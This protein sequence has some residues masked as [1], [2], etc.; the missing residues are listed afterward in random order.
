VDLLSNQVLE[1]FLSSLMV[2]TQGMLE[3]LKGTNGE[4]RNEHL[5]DFIS[6]N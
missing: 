4:E 2:E 3:S 6:L 5:S 1:H